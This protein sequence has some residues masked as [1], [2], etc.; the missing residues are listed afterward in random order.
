MVAH[1]IGLYLIAIISD[2]D[3]LVSED[4]LLAQVAC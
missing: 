4:S 2:S 1:E 3:V